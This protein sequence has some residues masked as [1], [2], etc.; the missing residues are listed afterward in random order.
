MFTTQYHIEEGAYLSLSKTVLFNL[1]IVGA[2]RE[3]G[4]GTRL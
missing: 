4:S 3:L 2:N 1:G